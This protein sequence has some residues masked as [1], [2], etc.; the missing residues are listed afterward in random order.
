M[1]ADT[2]SIDLFE[3]VDRHAQVHIANAL[4]GKAY[5]V[6][7]GVK[8][9]VLAGAVIFEFEQIVA[10]VESIHIFGLSGVNELFFHEFFS[11]IKIR[12]S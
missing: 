1:R 11:F 2:R 3:K 9:P 4:Y 7:T 8:H 12:G 10:I 6:F 5:R